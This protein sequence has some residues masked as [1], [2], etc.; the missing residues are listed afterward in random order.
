MNFCLYQKCMCECAYVYV[1]AYAWDS[2][3]W[4]AYVGMGV[5]V[6]FRLFYHFFVDFVKIKW[7]DQ[8]YSTVSKRLR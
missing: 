2:L 4:N 8:S 7:G 1:S 6:S 5:Y 3:G